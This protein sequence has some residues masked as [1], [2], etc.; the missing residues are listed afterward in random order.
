MARTLG[1]KSEDNSAAGGKRARFDSTKILYENNYKKKRN[2]EKVFAVSRAGGQSMASSSSGGGTSRWV[3]A[4][5][6]EVRRDATRGLLLPLLLLL[7]GC[8]ALCF[9]CVATAAPRSVVGLGAVSCELRAARGEE[10]P[11]I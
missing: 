2:D 8:V 10:N 4:W 11:F 5:D 7:V 6:S 3:V 9:L 1:R